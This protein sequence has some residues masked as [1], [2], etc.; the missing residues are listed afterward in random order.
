[1]RS[2]GHGYQGAVT[3]SR[4][5]ALDGVDSVDL[6]DPQDVEGP[7]IQ[8][9]PIKEKVIE[10][11]GER[12]FIKVHKKE[13]NKVVKQ[14]GLKKPVAVL[15]PMNAYLSIKNKLGPIEPSLSNAGSV[16]LGAKNKKPIIVNSKEI[17]NDTISKAINIE[18]SLGY[19]NPMDPG[20]LHNRKLIIVDNSLSLVLGDVMDGQVGS[21]VPKSA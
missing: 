17:V 3:G 14:V 8:E 2:N 19:D 7:K 10:Q 5:S 13:T 16:M 9:V 12:K 4:F 15:S 11:Q 18:A 20:E 6:V 21:V 1:M